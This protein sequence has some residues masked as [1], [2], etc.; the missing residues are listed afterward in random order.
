MAEASSLFISILSIQSCMALF[1]KL[2]FSGPTQS[3][4][5]S[6]STTDVEELPMLVF[7]TGNVKLLTPVA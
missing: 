1:N 2:V 7:V 6:L 5:L 3:A 4:Y